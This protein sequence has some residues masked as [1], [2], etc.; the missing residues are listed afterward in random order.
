MLLISATLLVS[1]CFRQKYPAEWAPRAP[2]IPAAESYACPLLAGVYD[3]V[4]VKPGVAWPVRLM[5]FMGKD[6]PGHYVRSGRSTIAQFGDDSLVVT[7]IE[8]VHSPPADSTATVIQE[9]RVLRRASGDYSCSPEGMQITYWESA[10]GGGIALG[11]KVRHR[12]RRA[13]DGALIVNTRESGFGVVLLIPFAA[14]IESWY[15]VAPALPD[16][17]TVRDTPSVD[18]RPE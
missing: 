16:S 11:T 10:G 2:A 6:V 15:R 12:F 17:S 14:R 1:A 3:A 7:S 18:K 9:R 4:G 8:T 5:S 13:L